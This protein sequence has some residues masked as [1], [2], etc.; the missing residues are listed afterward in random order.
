MRIRLHDKNFDLTIPTKR[1]Q[2]TI[3]DMAD[4]MN[5]QLLGKDV[6]FVAILNGAFMFA[7]DLFKRIEFD[8]YI[9]FIKFAF[10]GVPQ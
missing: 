2:D 9:S 3:Q 6:V 7:S 1:I 4:E 8:A 5:A 10:L